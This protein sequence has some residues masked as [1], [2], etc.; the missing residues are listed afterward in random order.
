M[1]RVVGGKE[2]PVPESPLVD[3][4][5]RVRAGWVA[6]LGDE[7][8]ALNY[9]YCAIRSQQWMHRR[10]DTL[11]LVTASLFAQ[12]TSLDFTIPP[13]APRYYHEDIGEFRVLPIFQARKEPLLN[14]DIKDDEGRD[15]PILTAA[16]TATLSLLGMLSYTQRL[17]MHLSDIVRTHRNGDGIQSRLESIGL[18]EM[19]GPELA[20]RARDCA[21]AMFFDHE[22]VHED[23]ERCRYG[24]NND[25]GHHVRFPRQ[26][27]HLRGSRD[28]AAIQEALGQIITGKHEAGLTALGVFECQCT[29]EDHVLIHLLWRVAPYRAFLR[30]FAEVYFVSAVLAMG[31]PRSEALLEV[32]GRSANRSLIA[33]L[34]GRV[35][36]RHDLE[37]RARDRAASS[38]KLSH[39]HQDGL[40]RRVVTFAL[41]REAT[42]TRL[43]NRMKRALP[44]QKVV[45]PFKDRVR[46]WGESAI[47]IPA[48]RLT[49]RL[50]LASLTIYTDAA[51]AQDCSSYHLEFNA[52]PGLKITDMTWWVL[53]VGLPPVKPTN[54][55]SSGPAEAGR[56][57][58]GGAAGPGGPDGRRLGPGFAEGPGKDSPTSL[59]IQTSPDFAGGQTSIR[60]HTTIS[61]VGLGYNLACQIRLRALALGWLLMANIVALTLAALLTALSSDLLASQGAPDGNIEAAVYQNRMTLAIAVV[62]LA[63]T[64]LLRTGEHAL[65]K[66]YLMASRLSIVLLLSTALSVTLRLA[67]LRYKQMFVPVPA[68]GVP[69]DL[70]QVLHLSWRDTVNTLLLLVVISCC[71]ALAVAQIIAMGPYRAL[72]RRIHRWFVPVELQKHYRY[73]RMRPSSS[74]HL[75]RKA[76][77]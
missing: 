53:P 68:W 51:V 1:V 76:E 28:A 20:A 37:G 47:Y 38:V 6:T 10:V 54:N 7:R 16:Q 26:G 17:F 13:G 29:S 75:R 11:S 52:P 23:P 46:R 43:R 14:F 22:W 62:A 49:E 64:L 31:A 72:R 25:E 4:P 65:T 61:Q 24:I 9:L 15:I 8:Q 55:R 35:M 42:T 19:V 77:P 74:R 33:R 2:E 45:V 34:I 12:R 56:V 67:V 32:G 44:D 5:P 18:Q 69:A 63:G 27:L 66:R 40:Q 50:G 30:R 21:A 48:R 58:G 71:A 41:D 73:M 60:G 39:T 59:V 3:R 70:G 36:G 57:P